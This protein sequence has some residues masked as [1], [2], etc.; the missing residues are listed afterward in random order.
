MLNNPIVMLLLLG[1]ALVAVM[2]FSALALKWL[3]RRLLGTKPR[4]SGIQRFDDQVDELL[5]VMGQRMDRPWM[6]EELYHVTA[7]DMDA[8]RA[9][10]AR[11]RRR[12]LVTQEWMTHPVTGADFEGFMLTDKGV[13]DF[14]MYAP[15]D[16]TTLSPQE[17]RAFDRDVAAPDPYGLEDEFDD[18]PGE[19][20]ADDEPTSPLTVPQ[21]RGMRRRSR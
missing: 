11:A 16:R 3:F 12:G 9:L 13:R 17:E 6:I 18:A 5:G 4:R 14:G 1:V 21:P 20:D 10:L 8:L 7:R 19:D 15:E 2:Y